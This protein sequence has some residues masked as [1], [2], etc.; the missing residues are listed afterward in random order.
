MRQRDV[1]LSSY[2][3]TIC[4]LLEVISKDGKK[5]KETITNLEGIL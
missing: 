4:T 2:W 1:D 3:G 5:L